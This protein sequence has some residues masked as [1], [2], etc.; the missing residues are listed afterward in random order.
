MEI[1]VKEVNDH[2]LIKVYNDAGMIIALS[3]LG[4]GI[5]EVRVPDKT[6]DTKTVTLCPVEEEENRYGYYGKTIGR[7]SGRIAEARFNIDG[8]VAFLEKNNFSRD[9]LHGGRT[10]LHAQVFGYEIIESEDFCDVV[11]SYLSK[12]DEGGYFGQADIKVTYRIFNTV[13]KF[14]IRFDADVNEKLLL[15]L[16]NH[17]YWNL[18]GDLSEKIT[19]EM[20]YINA[21]RYGKLNERLIVEKITP[22]TKHMDFRKPHKIGDFIDEED[23]QEFT[24]GYDHPF[25]FKTAGADKTACAAFSE[26]SGIRLDVRTTYPCVVLYTSNY[27][28]EHLELFRG[29][30]GSRYLGFCLECQYHPD[31]IHQMSENCGLCEPDKPYHEETEYLFSI[32][33]AVK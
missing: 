22:V 17:V 9:N 27:A 13:N 8:K 32:K 5:R 20:L 21:D 16:T 3:S 19:E 12:D 28:D 31:G 6:G 4:A 26:K 7:T 2:S 1:N 30:K 24:K 23:V 10:G 11:F 29:V 18:G 15:N 14:A 25:F 33:K